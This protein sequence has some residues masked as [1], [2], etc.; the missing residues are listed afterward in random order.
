MWT[1]VRWS[2]RFIVPPWYASC[3][4][5]SL[6]VTFL[7]PVLSKCFQTSDLSVLLVLLALLVPLALLPLL[8]AILTTYMW[9]CCA[10]ARNR[11]WNWWARCRCGH[12]FETI[13]LLSKVRWNE[14]TSECCNIC[15][16]TSY[17]C[18]STIKQRM[19]SWGN[20]DEGVT[21]VN[22]TS[23]NAF[24]HAIVSIVMMSQCTCF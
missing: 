14:W 18:R 11:Q 6:Q 24:T 23:V 13:T 4:A 12:R 16:T 7:V 19:I 22:T 15:P 21:D 2:R 17:E 1:R 9:C 5:H 10:I 8:V 3:L 20:N